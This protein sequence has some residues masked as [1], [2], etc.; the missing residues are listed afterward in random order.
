[1]LVREV[2][3]KGVSLTVFVALVHYPVYNRNREV[4][5]TAI[6]NLDVHDIARATRT[7]GGEAYFIVNP[8]ERQRWLL[9]R[10]VNHWQSGYGGQT[11]PNR[12]DALSIVVPV[13]T[14]EEALKETE[15]MCGQRVTTIG[16]TARAWPR[17]VSFQELRARMRSGGAYMILFGTGW[18]LTDETLSNCDLVLEPI[19]GVTDYNHLSVRAAAAII[20]DRVLGPELVSGLQAQP[21]RVAF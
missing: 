10:I 9:Q 17:A 19:Y 6:T 16:T 5:A 7:F 15:K 2:R 3:E 13:K 18:G 12:K 20:L 21:E 11:H 14:I 1:M 4:V 8:L